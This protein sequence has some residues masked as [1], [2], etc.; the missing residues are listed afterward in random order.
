M[1]RSLNTVK[2]DDNNR[3][4]H[5]IAAR[6]RKK[7]RKRHNIVIKNI[8]NPKPEDNEIIGGKWC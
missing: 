5:R 3:K 7:Q 8:Y 2:L 4:L 6:V 1:I